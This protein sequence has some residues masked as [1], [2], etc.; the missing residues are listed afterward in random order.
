M[1]KTGRTKKCHYRESR[2]R[3]MVVGHEEH[4]R[5][6]QLLDHDNPKGKETKP[7]RE[8]FDDAPRRNETNMTQS[9]HAHTTEKGSPWPEQRARGTNTKH[10]I[11]NTDARARQTRGKY[12]MVRYSLRR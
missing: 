10:R 5:P 1:D 12:S 8:P 3:D 7:D 11:R 4:A 2:I 9:G 6:I